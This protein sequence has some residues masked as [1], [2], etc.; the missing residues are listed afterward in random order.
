MS[1]LYLLIPLALL[2]ALGAVLAF[3]WTV[4]DG[5]LDDLESPPHRALFEDGADAVRWHTPRVPR[6]VPAQRSASSVPRAP[7]VSARE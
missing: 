7:Q 2:F 3:V 4:R 5:Q 6:V 1:V